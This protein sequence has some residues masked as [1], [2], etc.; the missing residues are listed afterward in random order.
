MKKKTLLEDILTTVSRCFVVLIIIVLL[1]IAF[2]GVRIVKSG[3]VAMVLRFGKIVGDTPEEQIH[4][5]GLLLCFPYFIDEV[6]TVPVGSVIQQTVTTHYTDGTIDKWSNSGYVITGDQ[7]IALISAS[8]KYIIS[9]PVA[10]ALYVNEVSSVIDACVSN[11]MLEKAAITPVDDILT[12]GKETYAADVIRESQRKLDEAGM[13]VSLQALELTNVS[14][15]EE[16]R[17]V[18]ENVNA[19]TV[20]ASTLLEGAQQ[21]YNTVIPYAE[22]VASSVISTANSSY[23]TAVSGAKSDLSEFW[24]ILEEYNAAPASVKARI[25]NEKMAKALAVIGQVRLVDDGDGKIFIEWE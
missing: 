19:A 18:Y 6:V 24:G 25:Y 20:E 16:V 10:Y 8:V 9:D 14:M 12:S 1:C 7:N 15:P 23:A 5:P 17:D 11:A 21:Y 13:G 2:S 4:N 22:S 3:E